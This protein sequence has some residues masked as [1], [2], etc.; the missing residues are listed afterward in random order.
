MALEPPIIGLIGQRDPV[1]HARR[2]RPWSRAFGTAALKEYEPIISKRVIQ[3]SE[4][5]ANQRGTL[6]LAKWFSYFTYVPAF[7][8]CPAVA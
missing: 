1:E 5:L 8:T 6:D 2:R 3:L 7:F 4:A